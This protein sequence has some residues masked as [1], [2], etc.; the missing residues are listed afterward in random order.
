MTYSGNMSSSW[1][2]PSESPS[3]APSA[4]KPF[5]RRWWFITLAVLFALGVIGSF[6]DEPTM[7][8]EA[9]QA[10]ASTSTS[11][12]T[13]TTVRPTTTST[14][15]TTTTLPPYTDEEYAAALKQMTV[16]DDDVVG[17]RFVIPK[18]SPQ[19]YSQDEFSIYISGTKASVGNIRFLARYAG[20][21]WVFFEKIIVNVDGRIFNLDFSYFEVKRDNGS[22]G[23]WEWVDIVPSSENIS[24]LKLIADSKSTIVRFQGDDYKNDRELTKKEKKAISDV[25]TVLDGYERGKLSW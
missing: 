10:V 3:A 8:S 20:S 19:Y 25:F 23:V 9:D 18:S 24:M 6:V 15:T 16:K 1:E 5:Y 2:P 21:D 17:S 11:S 14:T 7:D 12:T 13:S 4:T 22:G